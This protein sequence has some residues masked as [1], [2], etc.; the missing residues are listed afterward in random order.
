MEEIFTALKGQM[1][2]VNAFICYNFCYT[3][4]TMA[5]MFDGP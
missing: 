1:Q 4:A 2:A 5:A 3:I